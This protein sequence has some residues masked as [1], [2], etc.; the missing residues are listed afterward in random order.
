MTVGLY[1]PFRFRDDGVRRWRGYVVLKGSS[2]QY[3]IDGGDAKLHGKRARAIDGTMHAFALTGLE[4]GKPFPM[5]SIRRMDEKLDTTTE[6]PDLAGLVVIRGRIAGT[7]RSGFDLF[8]QPAAFGDGPSAV[9]ERDHAVQ[10]D[11]ARRPI[12]S[13]GFGCRQ[14]FLAIDGEIVLPQFIAAM[15]VGAGFTNCPRDRPGL[16]LLSASKLSRQTHEPKKSK[17]YRL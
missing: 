7:R 4:R 12:Q 17:Q 1:G 13:A 3:F 8:P 16:A 5:H 2:G 10:D 14:G 9:A 6:L 11:L 15:F